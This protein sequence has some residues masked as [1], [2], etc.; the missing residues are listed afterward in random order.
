MPKKKTENFEVLCRRLEE[1]VQRLEDEQLPLEESIKL[2]TEGVTLAS[3]ARAR[4]E[5]GEKTVQKLIQ[6]IDKKFT[7]EEL[8]S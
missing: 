2:F 3:K 4:L 1:I 6:T 7:L 8:E 5:E